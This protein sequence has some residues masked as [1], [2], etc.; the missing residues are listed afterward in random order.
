MKKLIALCFGA[1][2]L[3]A[4]MARAESVLVFAAISLSDA[5]NQIGADF[6]RETSI[7]VHYNLQGSSALARQIEAGAPA[8]LF[9]SADEEKMDQLQ[10]ENLIETSTRM[11]LLS[12]ILVMVTAPDNT[13]INTPA[14]LERDRVERIA[15]AQPDS[16]PAGI[17]AKRYLERIGLWE[18]LIPK[19][20]PTENVRSALAAVAAGNADAGFVYR[21]DATTSDR[22]RI[23]YEIPESDAPS[24]TYPVAVLR[25]APNKDAA[26]RFLSY[27]RSRAA[28]A[29]FEQYGFKVLSA[30]EP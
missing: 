24:I 7:S 16:V 1:A 18:E 12:N 9:F 17:Y 20:I 14:D 25:N 10:G 8:D 27:L 26:R 28:G 19:I 13:G 11:S 3:G 23:A 5:L 22:V 21:T 4:G 6:E 2:L 30:Q 15:L 29:V